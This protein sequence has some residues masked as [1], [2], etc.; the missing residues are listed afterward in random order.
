M[1]LIK[2]FKDD[3]AKAKD[4]FLSL[5]DRTLSASEPFG[6]AIC[7]FE[8]EWCVDWGYEEYVKDWINTTITMRTYEFWD[9]ETVAEWFKTNYQF[10]PTYHINFTSPYSNEQIEWFYDL[11]SRIARIGNE[12]V[13]YVDYT[14]QAQDKYLTQTKFIDWSL[15]HDLDV[16]CID[17]SLDF[18]IDALGGGD[19]RA[20]IKTNTYHYSGD[21]SS[22]PSHYYSNEN[23]SPQMILF[24]Y[25]KYATILCLLV[26]I[27][28]AFV[29][30]MKR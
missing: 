8:W 2:L 20:P 24:E 19:Q 10:T 16:N 29:K 14:K 30:K 13:S 28:I 9:L 26:V 27:Y 17:T 5:I 22:F 7:Q 23:M 1:N 15:P 18:E 12:V 3:I 4:Y 6:L 11:N 25:L 21:L